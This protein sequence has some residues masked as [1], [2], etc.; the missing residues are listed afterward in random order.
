M[1]G[2]LPRDVVIKSIESNPTLQEE[3]FTEARDVFLG[4]MPLPP[5]PLA[6]TPDSVA[7]ERYSVVA[8]V[9]AGGELTNCGRR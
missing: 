9:L 8:R 4:S 7:R 6:L 3:V 1:E 2:L 5:T